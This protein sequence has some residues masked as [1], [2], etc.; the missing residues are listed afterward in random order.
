MMVHTW[1]F[2]LCKLNSPI[3]CKDVVIPVELSH[4]FHSSFILCLY[5]TVVCYGLCKASLEEVITKQPEVLTNTIIRNTTK[6]IANNTSNS[7]WICI[8]RSSFSFSC[9]RSSSSPHSV[10]N[11][12]RKWRWWASSVMLTRPTDLSKW[13][14]HSL[15]STPWLSNC[16]FRFCEENQ[17]IRCKF[18]YREP[19][20]HEEE[21]RN[22]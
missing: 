3:D 14:R 16:A 1:K 19:T 7:T 17:D 8:W 21:C 2:S 10:L 4:R 9:N 12:V 5:L 22:I 20:L 11:W 15:S 6:T 13:S 18:L